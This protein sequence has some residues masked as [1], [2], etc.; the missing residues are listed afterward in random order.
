MVKS[1]KKILAG[2]MAAA[3]AFTAVPVAAATSPSTSTTP[4]VAEDVKA[5]A[6]KGITATVD[7][8]KDGT[9][10]VSKIAATSKKTVEIPPRVTVDGVSYK[11]TKLD[12]NAL[13][14]CK[15]ATTV[16]VPAAIDTISKNAFKGCTSVKTIK[17]I[18]RD[19]V[20]IE[21]GA[22]SGLDT[23]KITIVVNKKMKASEFK[24]LKAALKKAGFKGTVKKAA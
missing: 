4:V 12:S 22:F 7:T 17:M 6:V 3:I 13:S 9:A 14:G 11:V 5:E 10:T 1:M 16:R 18:T 8:A 20:K 15:K 23:T 24:K 2:L 21:K 19:G